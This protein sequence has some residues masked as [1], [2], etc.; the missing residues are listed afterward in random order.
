[1]KRNPVVTKLPTFYLSVYHSLTHFWQNTKVDR[2]DFVERYLM[3]KS[4]RNISVR[5]LFNASLSTVTICLALRLITVFRLSSSSKYRFYL[6]GI[7]MSCSM[8]FCRKGLTLRQE[9]PV[10]DFRRNS[11]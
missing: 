5:V 6:I 4:N 3:Q 10:V 2:D 7:E 1:M 8:A 11:P 9:T